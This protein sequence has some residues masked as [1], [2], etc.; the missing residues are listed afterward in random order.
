MKTKIAIGI[1]ALIIAGFFLFV[2]CCGNSLLI[3]FM[4][5]KGKLT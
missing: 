1:V 4:L 5:T 3:G 2:H